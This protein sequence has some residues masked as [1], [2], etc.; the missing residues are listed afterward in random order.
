[1][2]INLLIISCFVLFVVCCSKGSNSQDNPNPGPTPNPTP[3]GQVGFTTFVDDLAKGTYTTLDDA[4]GKITFLAGDPVAIMYGSGTTPTYTYA[5]QYINT[6]TATFIPATGETNINWADLITANTVGYIKAWYPNSM[7]APYGIKNMAK[8]PCTLEVPQTGAV[9]PYIYLYTKDDQNTQ[10]IKLVPQNN[11]IPLHFSHVMCRIDFN[12]IKDKGMGALVEL[13]KISVD[14]T[15]ISNN[16]TFDLKTSTFSKGDNSSPEVS[17]NTVAVEP[18]TML[19]TDFASAK[20]FSMVSNPTNIIQKDDGTEAKF[21]FTVK[22]GA[23][24][25][26]IEKV[27]TSYIRRDFQFESGMHY[28]FNVSLT[29]NGVGIEGSVEGWEDGETGNIEGT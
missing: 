26:L 7:V 22:M 20:K 9:S 18:G 2:K 29:E 17:I 6:G 24:G 14:G 27:L 4:T 3:D 13:I 19:T 12:V 8:I 11:M 10:N 16:G 25:N 5:K 23:A 28:T 1:M 21:T 15:E